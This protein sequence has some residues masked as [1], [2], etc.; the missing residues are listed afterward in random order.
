MTF[1]DK[2]KEYNP[3]LSLQALQ[4]QMEI[5]Y[6]IA[7]QQEHQKTLEKQQGNLKSPISFGDK[8]TDKEYEEY[9]NKISKKF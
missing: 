9:L 4:R 5:D 7:H 6:Y 1:Y 8:M 2:V 3:N